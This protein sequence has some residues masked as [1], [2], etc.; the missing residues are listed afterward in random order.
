MA[1]I[2]VTTRCETNT[3][4]LYLFYN[5]DVSE[6]LQIGDQRSEARKG[7]L[8]AITGEYATFYDYE[9]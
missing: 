5:Y 2:N 9:I 4:T 7:R 3:Q 8:A 6:Q 1:T